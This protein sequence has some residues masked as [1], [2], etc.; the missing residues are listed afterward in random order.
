MPKIETLSKLLPEFHFF[1]VGLFFGKSQDKEYIHVDI[2]HIHVDKEHIQVDLKKMLVIK[3]HFIIRI[4]NEVSIF[5][6]GLMESV[7]FFIIVLLREIV[8]EKE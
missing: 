5:P 6:N 3:M 4:L 1:V 2:E 7:R 8:S